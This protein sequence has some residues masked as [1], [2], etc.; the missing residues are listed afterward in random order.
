[1]V[2]GRG[3]GGALVVATRAS[4]RQRLPPPAGDAG[5]ES[6]ARGGGVGQ[7]HGRRGAR[8]RGGRGGALI[9]PP[10]A[11]LAPNEGHVGDQPLEFI[12]K[13]R[14]PPRSLLRLPTPFARVM[15]VE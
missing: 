15:E 8:S 9:A 1:M 6:S 13:L 12:V 14:G 3:C 5:A 4:G 10:P 11:I 7:G 2:R